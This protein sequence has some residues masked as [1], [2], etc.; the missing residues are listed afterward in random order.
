MSKANRMYKKSPKL[1][2][3]DKGNVEIQTPP[4]ADPETMPEDAAAG[5]AD[6]TPPMPS[7]EDDDF[8]DMQN[9]HLKDT[10]DMH[11]RHRQERKRHKGDKAAL[12][13]KHGSDIADMHKRHQ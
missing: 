8:A 12:N 13:D 9:R 5:P 4:N 2:R 10:A 11:H 1:G 6:A 7:D 3:N